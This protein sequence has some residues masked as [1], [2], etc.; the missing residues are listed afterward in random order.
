MLFLVLNYH[1]YIFLFLKKQQKQAHNTEG[2]F[3]NLGVL[4]LFALR[5][6]LTL[7]TNS[8]DILSIDSST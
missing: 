3:L 5:N 7:K 2:C 4:K 8:T 6:C 1:I